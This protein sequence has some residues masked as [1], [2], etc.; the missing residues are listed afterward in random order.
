[1]NKIFAFAVPALLA[2]SLISR[3][4]V[5]QPTTLSAQEV[6]DASAQKY[7][8]FARYEGTCS[9]LLDGESSADG[10][11]PLHLVSSANSVTVFERDKSLEITGDNGFGGKFEAYSTLTS[12]TIEVFGE[13]GKKVTLFEQTA[14]DTNASVEFLAGLTGISG[15]G[16]ATLAA[17]LLSKDEDLNPL[18][19]KG[20]V[21]LLPVR[22]LGTK[23]CYIVTKTDEE[24]KKVETFW[25]EKD[26]FLLR[27]LEVEMG[28]TKSPELTAEDLE[29]YP[30][31]MNMPDITT[32]YSKHI[33]V[34][35]TKVAR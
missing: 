16:G 13:N 33:S 1:M 3:P 2:L 9:T 14:P 21:A 28:E 22:N 20:I 32:H 17:L 26:S 19:A 12:T 25:I 34:F 5:A 10:D 8:G 6:L 15:G 35:A 11:A 29:K 24:N 23:T 18:R 27:R 31:L 4:A 30:Q 7:A